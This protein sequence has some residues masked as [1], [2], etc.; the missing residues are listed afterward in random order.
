MLDITRYR[1]KCDKVVNVHFDW[2]VRASA[3]K[4]FSREDIRGHERNMYDGRF[5]SLYLQT[6][7]CEEKKIRGCMRVI[8][9]ITLDVAR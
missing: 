2:V 1:R 8:R 6:I 9:C 4:V 7:H 5:G 3:S